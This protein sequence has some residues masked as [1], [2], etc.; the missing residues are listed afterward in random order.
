MRGCDGFLPSGISQRQQGPGPCGYPGGAVRRKI[1]EIPAFAALIKRPQLGG[2]QFF[3]LI[4]R[5]VGMAFKPAR[6]DIECLICHGQ[7]P[8]MLACIDLDLD[9]EQERWSILGQQAVG[10]PCTP[11]PCFRNGSPTHS[12]KIPRIVS[13]RGPIGPGSRCTRSM[14]SEKRSG[15]GKK[16]L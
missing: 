11:G 14:S 7:N 4:N 6:A 9:T 5:N 2:H 8:K 15:S 1:K 10:Q 16:S 3:D 13:N 12:R